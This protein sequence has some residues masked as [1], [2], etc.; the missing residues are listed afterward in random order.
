LQLGGHDNPLCLHH[1]CVRG[2]DN[3]NCETKRGEKMNIG[4]NSRD[5]AKLLIER[6]RGN[7]EIDVKIFR[8]LFLLG[9]G[10]LLREAD[11]ISYH[12]RN[13]EKSGRGI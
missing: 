7:D 12:L 10:C 11:S 4:E 13:R 1:W 8:R 5:V 3:S 6:S 9:L 2:V